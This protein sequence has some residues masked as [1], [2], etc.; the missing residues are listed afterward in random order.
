MKSEKGKD[1]CDNSG[2]EKGAAFCCSDSEKAS[3]G[4]VDSGKCGCSAKNEKA[5]SGCCT[6]MH[7]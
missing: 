4:T 6:M 1:C 5:G 3:C 2:K 7:S